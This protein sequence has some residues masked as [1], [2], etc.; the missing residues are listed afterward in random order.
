MKIKVRYIDIK[1]DESYLVGSDLGPAEKLFEYR[2]YHRSSSSRRCRCIHPG[3]VL[4]EN[5]Q[6]AR[7][8]AERH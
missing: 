7:R 2:T 8:C 6:F 4:S 3:M 1:A 5:E